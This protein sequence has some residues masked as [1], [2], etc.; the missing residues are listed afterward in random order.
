MYVRKKAGSSIQLEDKAVLYIA[1]NAG[2]P[3]GLFRDSAGY[4]ML[5][6]RIYAAQLAAAREMDRQLAPLAEQKA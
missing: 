4:A 5:Q 3:T 2:S 1:V 6:Q